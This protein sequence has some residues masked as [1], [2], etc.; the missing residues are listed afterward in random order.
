MVTDSF[1]SI[2]VCFIGILTTITYLWFNLI[3]LTE[4]PVIKLLANTKTAQWRKMNLEASE[5]NGTFH[6]I[7][8]TLYKQQT[9]YYISLIFL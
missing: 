4:A 5:I 2:K 9:R 1:P 8:V 3:T 7:N 6:K